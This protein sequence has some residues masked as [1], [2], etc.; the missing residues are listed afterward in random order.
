MRGILEEV[1]DARSVGAEVRDLHGGAPGGGNSRV[2]VSALR[3]G[4]SLNFVLTQPYF[5]KGFAKGRIHFDQ[6]GVHGAVSQDG[7]WQKQRCAALSQSGNGCCP[8]APQGDTVE[9]RDVIWTC[10]VSC[11]AL[12]IL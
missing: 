3:A 9:D 7:G 2:S 11:E 1:R 10:A 5:L 4:D 12:F 8:E 6:G